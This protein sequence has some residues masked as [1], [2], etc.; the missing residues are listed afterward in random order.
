[1][2]DFLGNDY[3]AMLASHRPWSCRTSDGGRRP[4]HSERAIRDWDRFL[5]TGTAEAGREAERRRAA[6]G[7]D[8]PSDILFTSGTT[9][10]PRAW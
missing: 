9:G 6:L 1:M 8:D 5:A 10:H 2:T 7:P 3:V 4:G